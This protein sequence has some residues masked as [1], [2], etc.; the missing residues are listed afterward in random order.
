MAYKINFDTSTQ[1]ISMIY[2][3]VIDLGLKLRAVEELTQTYAGK[4]GMKIMIDVREATMNMLLGEQEAFGE[5]LANHLELSEA[6][7][8]V[9]HESS[10]NPNAVIDFIAYQNGYQLQ[11]F[12]SLADATQWLIRP[13][14]A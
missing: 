4:G 2:S 14:V 7:V 13:N 12:I 8:A 10:F 3:G 5:Y 9:L 6:K 1:I 11:D